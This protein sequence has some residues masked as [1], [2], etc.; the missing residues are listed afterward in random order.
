[1]PK[2]R[3]DHVDRHARL[4]KKRRVHVPKVMEASRWKR[5]APTAS[6]L[7]SVSLVV[8]AD[9]LN[10]PCVGR[11]WIQRSAEPVDEDEPVPFPR[12]TRDGLVL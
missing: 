6:R 1:M 11:S 3:R 2:P 7:A 5:Q 10:Q 9:D 8:V 4:Q 12:F